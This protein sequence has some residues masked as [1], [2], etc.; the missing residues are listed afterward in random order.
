MNRDEFEERTGF[1]PSQSLYG[2]I[3]KYYTVFPGDKD[4][5]CKAYKENEDGTGSSVRSTNERGEAEWKD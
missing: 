4:E 1:F 2:I 5:F 3:E